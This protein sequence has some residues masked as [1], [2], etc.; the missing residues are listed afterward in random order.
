LVFMSISAARIDAIM[1]PIQWNS[2]NIK[3]E[4]IP[5]GYGRRHRQDGK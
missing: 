3:H 5:Y 4:E 1:K 2:T